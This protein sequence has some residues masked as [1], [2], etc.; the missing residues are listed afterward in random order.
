MGHVI[1]QAIMKAPQPA[2]K[3]TLEKSKMGSELKLAP[4]K[5]PERGNLVGDEV[6]KM[7]YNKV[8]KMTPFLDGQ[9]GRLI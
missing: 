7:G 3:I 4:E 8:N 5:S 9:A 2:K 1:A 6:P